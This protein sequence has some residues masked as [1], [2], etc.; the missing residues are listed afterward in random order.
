M[1]YWRL[2]LMCYIMQDHYGFVRKVRSILR[3]LVADDAH[4]IM[5]YLSGLQAPS[6][7]TGD[8]MTAIISPC[9]LSS[10]CHGFA[11]LKVQKVT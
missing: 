11:T 7:S 9:T 8:S 5:G 6:L 3:G 4:L 2:E 10:L 1:L